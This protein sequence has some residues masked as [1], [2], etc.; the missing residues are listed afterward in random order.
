MLKTPKRGFSVERVFTFRWHGGPGKIQ[1]FEAQWKFGQ[2]SAQRRNTWEQ[3]KDGLRMWIIVVYKE[4]PNPH[5]VAS[6]D[7]TENSLNF[8]VIWL[9]YL[10]HE[11]VCNA[12]ERVW[13]CSHLCPPV[14]CCSGW[15]CGAPMKGFVPER[16]PTSVQSHW[17][18]RENADRDQRLETAFLQRNATLNVF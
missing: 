5:T 2:L 1:M 8:Y 18:E 4:K 7:F 17:S 3:K 10:Q 6:G 12:C 13:T 14:S 9:K 16:T 11:H 15:M